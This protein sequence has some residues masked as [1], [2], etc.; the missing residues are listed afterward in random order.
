MI[1][2][3]N[4][5]G[6]SLYQED[7]DTVYAEDASGHVRQATLEEHFLYIFLL[8]LVLEENVDDCL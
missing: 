4:I 8:C 7:G 5:D 6:I 3:T 2:L 1:E